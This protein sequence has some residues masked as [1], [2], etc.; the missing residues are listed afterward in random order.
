VSDGVIHTGA[1]W[2]VSLLLIPVGHPKEPGLRVC[3]NRNG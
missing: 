1:V 3:V 2:Y